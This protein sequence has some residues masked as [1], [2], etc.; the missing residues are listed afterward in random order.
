MLVG[1]VVVWVPAAVS[2][3]LVLTA[4][5]VV[6]SAVAVATT[7]PLDCALLQPWPRQKY[8]CHSVTFSSRRNW[9]GS[10]PCNCW[11]ACQL[12]CNSPCRV[13]TGLVQRRQTPSR[14]D[15]TTTC[16]PPSTRRTMRS[17]APSKLTPGAT[18]LSYTAS[19]S[20]SHWPISAD[21]RS[22]RSLAALP[23]SRA[24]AMPDT[25]CQPIAAITA[26]ISSAT[27][28]ST[29]VKPGWRASKR[30]APAATRGPLKTAP[31]RWS[32]WPS[33]GRWRRSPP[34]PPA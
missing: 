17:D 18:G 30:R 29:S 34:R 3:V 10:G 15:H 9:P 21:R 25:P 8:T 16:T 13:A 23:M 6:T 2:T 11:P 22:V 31:S 19:R 5:G 1:F 27:S 7:S 28:T 4:T 24:L 12:C 32:G 14:S 26:M 20:C 33:P